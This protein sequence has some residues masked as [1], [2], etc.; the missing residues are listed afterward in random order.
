MM[1]KNVKTESHMPVLQSKLLWLRTS[2]KSD[3][4]SLLKI[5]QNYQTCF[6]L[7]SQNL[8]L[9]IYKSYLLLT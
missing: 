6:E 4:K 3:N 7:I 5:V 8:F 2:E 1:T 9:S